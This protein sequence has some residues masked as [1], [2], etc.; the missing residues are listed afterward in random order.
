MA[1]V[2]AILPLFEENRRP[3]YCLYYGIWYFAAAMT[4]FITT[5]I[6]KKHFKRPRPKLPS[7]PFR[8]RNLRGKEIDCSWPSGDATQAGVFFAFLNLNMPFILDRVPFGLGR[9]LA[10]IW[11]VNVGFGRVFFHCHYIGDVTSGALIGIIGTLVNTIIT[12]QLVY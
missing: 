9:T 8:L 1:I 3:Y 6:L 4:A 10:F 12:R 5:V 7:P 2:G 11:L